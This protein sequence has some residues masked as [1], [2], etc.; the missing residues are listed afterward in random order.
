MTRLAAASRICCR[1]LERTLLD[2]VL[3][4]VVVFLI[5]EVALI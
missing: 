5:S 2:E 3:T 1:H 4:V